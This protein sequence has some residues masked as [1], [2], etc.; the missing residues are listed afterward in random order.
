[1]FVMTSYVF[2]AK[3]LFAA[4][5]M[6]ATSYMDLKNREVPLKVW[7]IALPLAVALTYIE[8]ISLEYISLR[9]IYTYIVGVILITILSIIFYIFDF[10]GG[11]D[12]FALITFSVL[13]P[14]NIMNMYLIPPQLLLIL[15]ASLTGLI[16]SIAYFTYNIVK[17]NWKKLPDN[18]NLRQ[19]LLLMFLGIPVKPKDYVKMKFYYP[20]TLYECKSEPKIRFSFSIEEEYEEYIEKIQELLKNK[21]ISSDTYIWVTYGIPFLINI[22]IGFIITLIVRDLWI[23]SLIK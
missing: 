10:F 16:F 22:Y 19:K 18:I 4:I 2:L 12:M 9:S 5:L 7:I 15:Y 8:Y 13:F 14:L 11:A 20:L 6:G 1:M 17:K 21:C 23:S 3:T